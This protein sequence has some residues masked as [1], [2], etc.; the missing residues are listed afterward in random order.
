MGFVDVVPK[1][2]L[3]ETTFECDTP[4]CSCHL[5]SP[6]GQSIAE[7]AT[8]ENPRRAC[9]DFLIC[10]LTANLMTLFANAVPLNFAH[11]CPF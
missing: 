10:E 6:F 4:V 3:V 5:G 8:E 7:H 2:A 9:H 11:S 1:N